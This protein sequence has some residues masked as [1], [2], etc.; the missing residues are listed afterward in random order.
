[1]TD[2]Q[3]DGLPPVSQLT[4]LAGRDASR[5][6]VAGP[7]RWVCS[8]VFLVCS[9][10]SCSSPPSDEALTRVFDQHQ[11]T[12]E[13]LIT[14]LREDSSIRAIRRDWLDTLDGKEQRFDE[15][16]IT[17]DRPR[18]TAYREL[19][20]D[21][22]LSNGATRV[23]TD[24]CEFYLFEYGSGFVFSSE[25]KGFAYCETEPSPLVASLDSD[26]GIEPKKTTFRKLKPNWYLFYEYD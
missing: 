24:A 17:I 14:M 16:P 22:G 23:Q 6:A 1:V 20:R 21:L 26:P 10:T 13:R 12:F 2:T 25:S 9:L 15:Q 8:I 19:F 18:W 11:E 4:K 7:G 5:K 3:F